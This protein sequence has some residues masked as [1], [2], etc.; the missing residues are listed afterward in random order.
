MA[1][2]KIQESKRKARRSINCTFLGCMGDS[3]DRLRGL[4]SEKIDKIEI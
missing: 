4:G 3:W 1:S 2:Y